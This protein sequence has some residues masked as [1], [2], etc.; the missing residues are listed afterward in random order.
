MQES[1]C[2][3]ITPLSIFRVIEIAR[4]VSSESE[5]HGLMSNKEKQKSCFIQ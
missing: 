1:I 5:E 3:G 2:F 4:A